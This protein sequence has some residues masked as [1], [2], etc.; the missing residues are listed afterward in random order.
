M[1]YTFNK[2]ST[3]EHQG[4]ASGT[5]PD[6]G[7]ASYNLVGQSFATKDVGFTWN[8]SDGIFTMHGTNIDA[9][10]LI[11]YTVTD[12]LGLVSAPAYITIYFR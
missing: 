9:H 7:V 3:I 12:N 1:T 6:G 11:T 8:S 2:T 10:L 5:A 4:A